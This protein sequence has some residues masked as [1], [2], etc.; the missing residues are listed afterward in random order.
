MTEAIRNKIQKDIDE[1]RSGFTIVE[2]YTDDYDEYEQLY[3]VTCR[4]DYNGYSHT[5]KPQ[6]LRALRKYIK[7]IIEDGIVVNRERYFVM[8]NIEY[9][10]LRKPRSNQRGQPRKYVWPIKTQ[11]GSCK[12]KNY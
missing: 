4:N 12:T 6:C 8:D 3:W 11:I 9:N 1:I 7:T 2:S 10:N 5:V